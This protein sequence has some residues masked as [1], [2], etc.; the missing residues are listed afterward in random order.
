MQF[1]CFTLDMCLNWKCWTLDIGVSVAAWVAFKSEQ[2]SALH[3]ACN[4]CVCPAMRFPTCHCPGQNIS[5]LRTHTHMHTWQMIVKNLPVKFSL[6][7]S[8]QNKSCTSNL[9]FAAINNRIQATWVAVC[10]IRIAACNERHK[11]FDIII[12][13]VWGMHIPHVCSYCVDK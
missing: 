13:H 9:S 3:A 5:T 4:R 11:K 7:F 12:V 1:A 10:I 6:N 8:T 2:R